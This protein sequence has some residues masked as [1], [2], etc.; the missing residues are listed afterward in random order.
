MDSEL[1]MIRKS[2]LGCGDMILKLC[3]DCIFGMIMLFSQR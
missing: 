1:I 3:S 2:K